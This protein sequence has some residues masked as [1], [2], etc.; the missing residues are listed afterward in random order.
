MTFNIFQ[1]GLVVFTLRSL[2]LLAVPAV[3][4]FKAF[5][6]VAMFAQGRLRRAGTFTK[7]S[8]A[9]RNYYLPNGQSFALQ[10]KNHLGSIEKLI[11]IHY[12]SKGCRATRKA[13][14]FDSASSR[15]RTNLHNQYVMAFYYIYQATLCLFVFGKKTQLER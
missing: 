12:V 6:D 5:F 14:S 9:L 3:C 1:D 11:F 13:M 15:V 7:F 10:R 8:V 4:V 2:S